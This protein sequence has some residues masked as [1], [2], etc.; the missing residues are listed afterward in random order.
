MTSRLVSSFF[1]KIVKKF[2]KTNLLTN[3][4]FISTNTSTEDGLNKI[5]QQL[6]MTNLILGF[7]AGVGISSSVVYYCSGD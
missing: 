6:Q 7:I 4:R 5:A 1:P 2:P 3:K